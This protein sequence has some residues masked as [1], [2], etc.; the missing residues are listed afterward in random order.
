LRNGA[1]PAGRSRSA[2]AYKTW[3]EDNNRRP[4]AAQRFN[5]RLRELCGQ[6]LDEIA[7]DGR[8]YWIGINLREQP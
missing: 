5:R 3:C 8:D 6:Q 4:L 1:K 2:T 7:S